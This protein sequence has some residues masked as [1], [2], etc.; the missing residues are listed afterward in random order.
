MTQRI[1]ELR[2]VFPPEGVP[3]YLRQARVDDIELL[4]DWVLGFNVDASLLPMELAEARG[5]AERRVEAGDIFIWE[6]EVRPVSMAAKSR[7]TSHGITISLVYTPRAL[8]NHGYASSCVAALSQQ[9]LDA[10]WEFCTLYTDLANPTS[11]GI[12]QRIGYRPVCDSSEYHFD[13]D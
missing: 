1:Y 6:N 8:R 13:N 9:L 10:G 4:T 11:N 2:Q 7:P 3:G 5:L 12:Y